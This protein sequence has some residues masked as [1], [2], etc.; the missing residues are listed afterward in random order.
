[1]LVEHKSLILFRGWPKSF[2]F[3]ITIQTVSELTLNELVN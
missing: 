1:M 3:Y 2:I